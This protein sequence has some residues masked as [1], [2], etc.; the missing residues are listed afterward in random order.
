MLH[1]VVGM[2]EGGSNPSG[3]RDSLHHS[4]SCWPWGPSSLLSGE[5]LDSFLG[6]NWLC[7]WCDHP[8]SHLL[9]RSRISTAVS[10]LPLWTGDGMYALTLSLTF[11]GLHHRSVIMFDVAETE[12]QSGIIMQT[13]WWM[14]YHIL[15][16]L[17]SSSNCASY[18]VFTDDWGCWPCLLKCS[19]AVWTRKPYFDVHMQKWFRLLYHLFAMLGMGWLSLGVYKFT[20]YGIHFSISCV[21]RVL[22]NMSHTED[23][24][25]LCAAVQNKV[26]CAV[27]YPHCG[28]LT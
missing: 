12:S 26:T 15:V 1:G 10:V 5:Y 6:I 7:V 17:Q 9:P 4:H 11:L 3:T 23:S 28:Q 20:K 19:H 27:L 14:F 18:S 22:W 2:T 8:H 24:K 25:I 21:S 13:P 16:K